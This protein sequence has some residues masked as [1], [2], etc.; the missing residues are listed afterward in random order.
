M[1]GRQAVGHLAEIRIGACVR[2]LVRVQMGQRERDTIAAGTTA[3]QG[4]SQG[5]VQPGSPATHWV[6]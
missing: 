1:V 5:V 6:T 4:V 2:W 3:A